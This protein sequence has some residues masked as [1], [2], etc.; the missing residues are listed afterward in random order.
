MGH[1]DFRAGKKIMATL[2]HKDGLEWGM[3]KLKPDQ[4]LRLVREYPTVFQPIAGGWGRQGCTK[5]CLK[6]ARVPMVREALLLAWR[7]IAP[8][9]LTR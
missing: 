7:N 8:A 4:Q 5:V 3:V 2:F 1:P 9:S 6:N